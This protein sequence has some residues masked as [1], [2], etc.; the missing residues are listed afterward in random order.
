MPAEHVT[1]LTGLVPD[2]PPTVTVHGVDSLEGSPRPVKAALLVWAAYPEGWAAGICWPW[3]RFRG[4]QLRALLT[5][6]VRAKQVEPFDGVDYSRVPRI[7]V[8]GGVDAWP[9][10]PPAYPKLDR[11]VWLPL[12]LHAPRPDATGE[13]LPLRAAMRELSRLRS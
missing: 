9:A 10:L 5:M 4:N 11:G 7:L 3:Q 2:D 1:S 13:Y 12:H 6:W 8:S